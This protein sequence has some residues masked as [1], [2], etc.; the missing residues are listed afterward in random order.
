MLEKIDLSKKVDKKTYRRVMDEAEEKL[1]LLQRECKDAGIP[2]I[3]VFEGMGAAGKGVQINR[4][5]QALDPRGFDV[6][7]CDRPTEDEQMRPFLWRYWT[8]TPAKGRIAVF[9][10]SWYRSVQVDRFDGLTREDK[11]GDAYQDI[12]SFEKQLCDDGTVIMKF[13]LYID[14]DEQKKRF[15]KLEGSKETSWRVTEEDWN[16]NKDFDRYLKMNEEMLEKTDTD[17]A[18]WVIIEAVDKD[19]AALKIVSTVMDRLEYELE[20]RRPEDEKTAQRQESKTRERFK[21]GVLSGIDLSK[22]LTEEEYKTRL[23]KLQKRLA[24][25]HSELYRL[26]IPVVIGFEGWDAG[27]KGGAIKRLTSNLDPRG[28]R[29]NPTA[30]PNDIEKVHHYLWRFWNSVPK[31]GHI[32]IFDRTWYGRVMVERIEGFCSEAE[33]RRAYQE[34]NE[35]ES[36]MANAGAV[37]LKFW[38]H[39]DKDEQE[40]RF[41]ERQ[42]NPAKQW[43]ITDEDWRNREKWDQ[44]EEAVNEMLI[45]TST[46]YAPWIVVE[47]NDKRYARVKVLQTVVDALEKKVKEVK[48]DK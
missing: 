40:R 45:R 47:G 48:T 24:E 26:R 5:I 2:V 19:Y 46:T 22:S 9:D 6:Y 3:L 27:G 12:L 1:G 34:I 25:L 33:W 14:K 31:A 8:K 39:I 44:Y 17:Y 7:A 37:V 16:R 41:R 21:N 32:A 30:A 15:K 20:H 38:L 35:M 43:K 23:K 11:L 18:P 29:V 13:F 28:Y 4:L 10:R 42:A 36:H